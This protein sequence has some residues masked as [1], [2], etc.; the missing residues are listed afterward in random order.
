MFGQA[1][2]ASWQRFIVSVLWMSVLAGCSIARGAQ[3]SQA[4]HAPVTAS[5][6]ET[7]RAALP[8]P[9]ARP[10]QNPRGREARARACPGIESLDKPTASECTMADCLGE[11]FVLWLVPPANVPAGFYEIVVSA[12]AE[13]I[14]CSAT[15]PFDSPAR[16]R[17]ACEGEIA[18]PDDLLFEDVP[19]KLEALRFNEAFPQN[20]S[21]E[22]YRDG[23]RIAAGQLNP[24]YGVDQP[25]GAGCDPACCTGGGKLKLQRTH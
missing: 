15:G 22:M 20:V 11:G 13:R 14:S 12:D 18:H 23:E 17:L 16:R 7:R 1:S 25:N 4:Q 10:P 2:R 19:G 21:A 3:R 24:T 8:S 5:P 6:H 9:E